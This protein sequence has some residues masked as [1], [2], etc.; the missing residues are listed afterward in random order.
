MSVLITL[1]RLCESKDASIID[2]L[3]NE[4]ANISGFVL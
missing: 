4:I 2:A 1:T 3:E